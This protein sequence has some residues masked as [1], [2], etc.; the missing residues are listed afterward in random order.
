MAD[1]TALS[2]PSSPQGDEIRTI[3]RSLNVPAGTSK[4]QVVA[5]DVGGEAGESL[6][7]VG[8]LPVNAPNTDALLQQILMTLQAINVQLSLMISGDGYVDPSS[9]SGG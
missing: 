8:G 7:G 3:D 9:M 1:N 2:T 5:L 6:V 4:T